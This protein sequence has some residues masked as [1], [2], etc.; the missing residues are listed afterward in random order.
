MNHVLLYSTNCKM[1]L[2]EAASA[3]L[4]APSNRIA[5]NFFS[6]S[7]AS[8]VDRLVNLLIGIYARHLFG[9]AIIGKLAWSSSVVS[10]AALVVNPGLETIARREVARDPKQATRYAVLLFAIQ[11]VLALVA[12]ALIYVF[13]N[14]SGRERQIQL[15]LALNAISLLIVPFD[16]GWLLQAHERLTTLAMLNVALVLLQAAA[17]FAFIRGAEQMF[18]YVL[19]PYPFRAVAV[20]FSL[21]FSLRRGWLDLRGLRFRWADVRPLMQAAL[22]IGLA[23]G[24]VMLYGNSDVIFLGFTHSS[25][26]VGLYSTAYSMMLVPTFLHAA[27]TNSYFATLARAHDLPELAQQVSRQ[28]LRLMIWIG[29][30]IASIGWA[31]GRHPILLL[32]GSNFSGSG[33]LF[34]WLSLNLVFLFF[35]VGYLYPLI[36][37]ER[38]GLAFRCTVAG[39]VV[40]L[41]L[42]FW[43]IP[44]FGGGGAAASTILSEAAVFASI[45]LIRRTIYPLPWPRFLLPPLA[46]CALI[47]LAT[48]WASLFLM[49]W[50]C[51]AILGAI[52]CGASCA[53][54]ERDWTKSVVQRLKGRKRG[55]SS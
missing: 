46:A 33:P 22:P 6:S 52:A 34:E 25:S 9:A 29:L 55:A 7:A 47:A 17:M 38:A 2:P 14:V 43:L 44:R 48:R 50:W 24:T 54:L 10:Y 42:N 49:P 27:L 16:F 18:L 40:N 31:V 36:T 51:A 32:F 30:P 28:F 26:E 19:L 12:F 1:N 45:I 11:I 39:A 5:R 53:F 4:P 8:L 41:A 3:P 35:N 15:L 13:G 20:G 21:W 37:W 23:H